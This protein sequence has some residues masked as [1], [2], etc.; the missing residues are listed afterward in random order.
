MKK[1]HVCQQKGCHNPTRDPK[2]SGKGYTIHYRD[3]H[4]CANLMSN[5]GITS[6]ERYQMCEDI[7]WICPGCKEEMHLPPLGDATNRHPKNAAVDH[8][9]SK[10]KGETGFIRGILCSACNRG[11]GMLGDDPDRLERLAKHLRG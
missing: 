9:H 7:D 5:Y 4:T 11:M 10:L 1:Y 3:C 8:D 2:P 6:P